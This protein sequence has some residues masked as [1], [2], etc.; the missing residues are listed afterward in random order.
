M[1]LKRRG[2]VSK[3]MWN[4]N[5][6]RVCKNF[7]VQWVTMLRP[8]VKIKQMTRIGLTTWPILSKNNA[9]FAIVNCFFIFK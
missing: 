4:H 9:L 2:N 6:L 7:S 1:S 5:N 3:K 8:I